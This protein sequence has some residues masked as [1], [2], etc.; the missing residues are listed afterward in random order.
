MDNWKGANPAGQG[1]FMTSIKGYGAAHKGAAKA[2][3]RKRKKSLAFKQ[4]L[5]KKAMRSSILGVI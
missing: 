4:E 2:A 1:S 5:L 3:D